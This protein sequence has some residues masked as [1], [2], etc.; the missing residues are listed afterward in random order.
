ME[1]VRPATD[2]DGLGAEIIRVQSAELKASLERKGQRGFVDATNEPGPEDVPG[3]SSE[4]PGTEDLTETRNQGSGDVPMPTIPAGRQADLL[5]AERSHDRVEPPVH[6][7]GS[8]SESSSSSSS[9]PPS[10]ETT[11]KRQTSS[12]DSDPKRPK[13]DGSSSPARSLD[14]EFS[15]VAASEPGQP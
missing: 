8:S 6:D 10:Q 4:P 12:V 11:P 5:P 7:S 9:S 14:K 3:S 1:R 2:Q 13:L 15:S